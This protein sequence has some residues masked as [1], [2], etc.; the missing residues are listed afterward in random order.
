VPGQNLPDKQEENAATSGSDRPDER[1]TAAPAV[2]PFRRAVLVVALLNLAYFV[3]E[4]VIALLIGS[5]SLF[6]DGVDFLEDAAINLLVFVAATWAPRARALVGRGLALVI[7]VPAVAALVAALVKILHPVPPDVAPLS[8]TAVG[9]LLVNVVCAVIL[10]R[11]RNH[12][13]SLA[14]GAWLAARNDS[15]ANLGILAA[16]LLSIPLRSGWPDI[17][18]GIAIG[19][20]NAGAAREVWHEAS[21]DHLGVLDAE[22]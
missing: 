21:E 3:V 5:V 16:G 11:H 8:V 1:P 7:L 17:V 19:L 9:A 4:F 20:L 22:A 14:R 15:F 6:A 10:V 13:G 18:V 12:P 2:A